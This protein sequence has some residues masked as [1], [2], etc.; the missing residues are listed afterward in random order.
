[1]AIRTDA[2]AVK[3]VMAPGRDYDTKRNPDLTP[4]ITAASRVVDRLA[5]AALAAELEAPY[6]LEEADALLVETWLSAHFYKQSDKGFTSR[7]TE[8]ASGSFQ[9]QT[10]MGLDSTLYGQTAKSL[11]PTGFLPGIMDP[12]KASGEVGGFWLGTAW[13]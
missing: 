5:A 7:S 2:D 1:M 10:T 11:D 13:E 9:G 4:F 3:K 8:G 12:A 6:A